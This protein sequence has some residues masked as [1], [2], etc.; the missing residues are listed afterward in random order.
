MK[1]SFHLPGEQLIY[2]KGDDEVETVLNQHALDNSMFLAWFELNK[3][4]S[5]ARELTYVDIPTKFT[6]NHKDKTFSKREKGFAIG[7][8]NYVPRQIEDGYYMRMLLNVQVGAT[9]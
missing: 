4:S 6:Y 7:R 5:I 2:F 1:L 9:S 3:V 8:N